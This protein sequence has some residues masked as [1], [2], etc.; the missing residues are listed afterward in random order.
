MQ[1]KNVFCVHRTCALTLKNYEQSYTRRKRSNTGSFARRIFIVWDENSLFCEIN[2]W[3]LRTRNHQNLILYVNHF[4]IAMEHYLMLSIKS[5]S[6]CKN[7]ANWWSFS[8]HPTR[9]GGCFYP[10]WPTVHIQDNPLEEPEV[11]CLACQLH[12]MLTWLA[13]YCQFS[14]F[15][16][17]VS[18]RNQKKERRNYIL[19]N[20]VWRK[21]YGS[22]IPPQN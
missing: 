3:L 7:W 20:I 2:Y 13:F 22:L 18:P 12:T 16:G 5:G 4:G 1:W 11:K 14:A 17:H 8:D 10:Q 19:Q 9:T 15:P 21:L 6:Q